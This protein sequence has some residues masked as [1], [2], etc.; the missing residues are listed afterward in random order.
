MRYGPGEKWTIRHARAL[1]DAFG[2]DGIAFPHNAVPLVP[3]MEVVLWAAG[4]RQQ[5]TVEVICARWEVCRA[6]GYRW[7]AELY[8]DIAVAGHR[9]AAGAARARVRPNEAGP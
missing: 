5:A 8:G 7:H 6:T 9:S 4:L 1:A 3:Y 2:V